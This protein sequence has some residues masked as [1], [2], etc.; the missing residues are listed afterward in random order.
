MGISWKD[1][2]SL[3]HLDLRANRCPGYSTIELFDLF[4]VDPVASPPRITLLDGRFIRRNLARA[5]RQ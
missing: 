5:E 3:F 2:H 1:Q 4:G